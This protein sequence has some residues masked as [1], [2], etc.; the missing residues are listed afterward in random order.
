MGE[1]APVVMPAT[2]V[3]TV[4]TVSDVAPLSGGETPRGAALRRRRLRRA[5]WICLARMRRCCM[6]MMLGTLALLDLQ[7]TAQRTVQ[8]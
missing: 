5:N 6:I 3:Q 7:G 8:R 2:L 4:E 1:D